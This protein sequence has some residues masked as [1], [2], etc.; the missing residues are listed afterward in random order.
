[1]TTYF[2]DGLKEVTILN[3]VARLEFHRFRPTGSGAAAPGGANREM[4]S[5]TE[6]ILAMP[7]HGFLQAMAVLDQ[8]R[9]Q[10]VKEGVVKPADPAAPRPPPPADRSPNFS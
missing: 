4:Q 3:G 2:C 10:L 8:V 7:T 5:I 6:M 9:E 1:M